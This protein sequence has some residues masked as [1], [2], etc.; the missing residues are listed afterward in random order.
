MFPSGFPDSS[1]SRKPFCVK[2]TEILCANRDPNAFSLRHGNVSSRP[3][4][5]ARNSVMPSTSGSG[6]RF[7]VNGEDYTT[8]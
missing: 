2:D 8:V 4:G 6:V 3:L 1:V 7:G 5:V